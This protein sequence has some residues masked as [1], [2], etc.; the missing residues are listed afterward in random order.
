MGRKFRGDPELPA[1]ALILFGAA[2]QDGSGMRQIHLLG[3][4]AAHYEKWQQIAASAARDEEMALDGIA[5]Y[6]TEL[7]E[8]PFPFLCRCAPAEWQTRPLCVT[9]A[10]LA[11]E[12]RAAETDDARGDE[13]RERRPWRGR[14]GQR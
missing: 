9:H 3:G 8:I 1:F 6:R 5:V 14:P 4:T 2:A 7:V 10:A 11:A 12:W 13:G